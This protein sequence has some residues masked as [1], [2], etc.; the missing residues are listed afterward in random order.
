MTTIKLAFD[1]LWIKN[2]TNKNKMLECHFSLQEISYEQEMMVQTIYYDH[3]LNQYVL[4]DEWGSD[5]S[6]KQWSEVES[7]LIQQEIDVLMEF[8]NIERND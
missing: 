4:I 8:I 1:P 5:I 2:N 6:F 3:Q 7:F